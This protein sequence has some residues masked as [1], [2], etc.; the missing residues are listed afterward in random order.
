MSNTATSA[1][2]QHLLALSNL[3]IHRD[4]RVN[5]ERT[6]QEVISGIRLGKNRMF[7]DV[8][9]D[10]VAG[11]PRGEG[12]VVDLYYVN[13]KDHFS[14]SKAG[15]WTRPN[16]IKC[17]DLERWLKELELIIADPYAQIADN[18]ANP[19]FSDK[20]KNLVYWKN[21]RNEQCCCSFGNFGTFASEVRVKN[22]NTDLLSDDDWVVCYKI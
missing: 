2:L 16:W 7:V 9:D 4:V 21:T 3:I 11:M 22:K 12:N 20:H 8:T 1:G 17:K 13:A 6:P 18:E 5:R 15:N 14:Y 10:V 19:S